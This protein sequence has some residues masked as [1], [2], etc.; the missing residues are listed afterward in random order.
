MRL[1]IIELD[2]LVLNA[3]VL[4]HF[5]TC[6]CEF[7]IGAR[8]LYCLTWLKPG[9]LRTTWLDFLMPYS[10]NQWRILLWPTHWGFRRCLNSIFSPCWR[11]S[12]AGIQFCFTL[13]GDILE[14]TIGPQI[15]YSEANF[16]VWVGIFPNF[17]RYVR[18]C[19]QYLSSD[20][21]TWRK[22]WSHA[23]WCLSSNLDD[24]QYD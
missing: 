21:Q 3:V 2:L 7:L 14:L 1:R 13:F 23:D 8:Q 12:F 20:Y 16:L 6:I 4:S 18:V 22:G 19:F 15:C 11:R 9:C 24:L 5:L 17:E 10:Q